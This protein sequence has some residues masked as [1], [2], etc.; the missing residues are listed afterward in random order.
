MAT[1]VS[2]FTDIVS[3]AKS[4]GSKLNRTKGGRDVGIYIYSLRTKNSMVMHYVNNS[5]GLILREYLELGLDNCYIEGSNG[6]YL[7]IVVKPKEENT[8]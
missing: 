8:I 6:N 2:N 3:L 1:E 7:E 4:K 5:S